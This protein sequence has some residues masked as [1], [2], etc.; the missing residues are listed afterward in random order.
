HVGDPKTATNLDELATRHNHLASGCD[1]SEH[2]QCG[3]RI[4]VHDNGSFGA[5]ETA[6]QGFGMGIA[7]AAGA[8][9]DLVLPSG[10]TASDGENSVERRFR[11]RSAPEVGVKDD[12]RCVDHGLQRRLRTSLEFR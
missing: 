10:I 2:E 8:A 11:E 1:S 9:I 4:V 6:E 5:G 12:A 7:A 3:S